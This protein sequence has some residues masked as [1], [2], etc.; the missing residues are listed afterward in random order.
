[1]KFFEN[2][3]KKLVTVFLAT[4]VVA[5]HMCVFS[6]DF[7]PF[8]VSTP[9]FEVEAQIAETT[10][11]GG[12]IS[13]PLGI[14]PSPSTGAVSLFSVRNDVL[15]Q[16]Y[17]MRDY[18]YV[19]SV[20]SQGSLGVCWT[21]AGMSNLESYILRHID[22]DANPDFSENHMRF[23]MSRYASDG[24]WL[25]G[26]D[27]TPDAG[28]NSLYTTAY[29][30]RG[31]GPAGETDDPFVYD[32]TLRRTISQLETENGIKKDLPVD[33]G[34]G[35]YL[36][37]TNGKYLLTD[38]TVM[39]MTDD[40]ETN[41]EKIKRAVYTT[42]AVDIGVYWDTSRYVSGANMY[43]DAPLGSNHEVDI[44]GWDDSY[45]AS[46]FK[47]TPTVTLTYSDGTKATFGNTVPAGDGA[48]LVKNSWGTGR[49]DKGYFWLSYYDVDLS[50]SS[51]EVCYISGVSTEKYDNIYQYDPLVKNAWIPI[52]A[53]QAP[54]VT[55]SAMFNAKYGETVSAAGFYT[56]NES[57]DYRIFVDTSPMVSDS[58]DY[59]IT[60]NPVLVAEG[61][62]PNAGYHMIEFDEIPVTGTRF[63]ITAEITVPDGT[64]IIKVPLEMP[65][66]DSLGN[67][68]NSNASAN[69]KETFFSTAAVDSS[70]YNRMYDVTKYVTGAETASA[71]IKAFTN[72]P[73]HDSG[74]SGYVSYNAPVGN[75][76]AVFSLANNTGG[77]QTAMCVTAVYNGDVLENAFVTEKTFSDGA[78]VTGVPFTVSSSDCTVKSMIFYKDSLRPVMPVGAT[79]QRVYIPTSQQF[80]DSVICLKPGESRSLNI[81][82]GG[83]DMTYRYTFTSADTNVATVS[84]G[85]ITAGSTPGYTTV[86]AKCGFET[87]TAE[88]Y[89]IY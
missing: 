39:A 4:T 2:I 76:N 5:T 74:L 46:N 15:P 24:N 47:R 19:T 71:A 6:E 72:D 32:T 63:C 17:D 70:G 42:N 66:H 11:S 88:V 56:M 3:S 44:I 69:I 12:Y 48:F 22:P 18:G 33:I 9:D 81:L 78:A 58:Y 51:T 30:S 54:T 27:R 85:I 20:K 28:G 16:K 23:S 84:N 7:N 35:N 34:N 31:S 68:A 40:R 60:D 26:G 87:V 62:I 83:N 59:I 14:E 75:G 29:L 73:K 61:N 77:E 25:W 55:F 37:G 38:T 41:I 43:C 10:E 49:G 57:C 64:S 13:M 89:V 80:G 67:T 8:D 36:S 50:R 86:T 82:D 79:R 45:P 21:F 1:M 52:D 65:G 53:T